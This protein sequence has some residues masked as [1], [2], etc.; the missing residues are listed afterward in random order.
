MSGQPPVKNTKFTGGGTPINALLNPQQQQ[1]QM[2]IPQQQQQQ[3]QMAMQ[4]QQQRMS[5][6]Q[7]QQQQQMA[8]Q[9]QQQQQMLAMQQQQQQM[10]KILPKKNMTEK[11]QNFTGCNWK[12]L[13]AIVII[14]ILFNNSFIYDCEKTFLPLSLRFGNPPLAAVIFNAIIAG[15]IFLLIN[16]LIN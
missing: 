15:I 8:M 9:H 7:Q 1:Q 16:K 13:V 2:N 6:Q 3:Q 5:P 10:A 4:Q 11:F 14:F 12:L